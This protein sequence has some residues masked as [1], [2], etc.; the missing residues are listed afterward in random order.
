MSNQFS[1][2]KSQKIFFITLGCR[3]NQA[4]SL[5]LKEEALK[6]GFVVVRDEKEADILIVNSCSVTDKAQRDTE[7]TLKSLSQKYPS[8]KL[9]VTGCGARDE[10]KKYAVVVKNEEKG[11]LFSLLSSSGLTRGSR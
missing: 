9:V 5:S 1:N 11:D 8:K 10:H 3:L 6:R 2:S 7:K 4:E